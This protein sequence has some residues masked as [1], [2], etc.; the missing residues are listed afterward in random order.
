MTGQATA[1]WRR[2]HRC[3]RPCRS[4]AS[5]RRSVPGPAATATRVCTSKPATNAST[6]SLPETGTSSLAAA[7]AGHSGALPWMVV[8]SG[9]KV[10]SK[11]STCAA[12]PLASAACPAVLRSRVPTMPA[13]RDPSG[14]IARIA[15][16]T[17][18]LSGVAGAGDGAAEP[19]DEAADGLVRDVLGK[20]LGPYTGSE[21]GQRAADRFSIAHRQTPVCNTERNSVIQTTWHQTREATT[22]GPPSR[23]AR[24]STSCVTPPPPTSPPRCCTRA[25]G[26]CWITSASPSRAQRRTRRTDRQGAVPRT[27]R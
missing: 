23:R 17:R 3:V 9:L 18:P 27:R 11:S 15:A 6:A 4:R 2:R 16:R 25:P 10:S 5:R 13:A 26:A 14:S 21:G 19:V 20:V 7:I 22:I 1:R 12:M 24:C 8:R